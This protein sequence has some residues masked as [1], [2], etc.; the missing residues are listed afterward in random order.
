APG[1]DAALEAIHVARVCAGA[2]GV[3][4]VLVVARTAREVTRGGMVGAGER[5]VRDA[6]ALDVLVSA[7]LAAEAIQVFLAQDLA[8]IERLLGV[9]ESRSHPQVHAEVEIREHEHRRLET[10]GVVDR[11]APELVALIDR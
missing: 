6:V 10:V 2:L 3:P 1:L 11:V 9:L 5:A 7:P 8:S 4:G